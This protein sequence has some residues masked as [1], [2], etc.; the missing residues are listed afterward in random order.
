MALESNRTPMNSRDVDAG[1]VFPEAIGI[2]R[3][4]QR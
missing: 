3:S 2:F 4:V 1:K